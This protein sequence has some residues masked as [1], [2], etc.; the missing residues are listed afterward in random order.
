[1]SRVYNRLFRGACWIAAAGLVCF[2]RIDTRD[3]KK[4][5]FFFS[6]PKI[7]DPQKRSLSFNKASKMLF[8][9]VVLHFHYPTQVVFKLC[10]L[11]RVYCLV[12]SFSSIFK[13][14]FCFQLLF[15]SLESVK[16]GCMVAHI[17]LG[18]AR[19]Y[20]HDDAG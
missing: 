18:P 15:C 13:F 9:L 8:L 19:R 6:T 10:N 5:K 20:L 16:C 12:L 4:R 1:M 17:P 7:I 11:F 14:S 3:H 2:S